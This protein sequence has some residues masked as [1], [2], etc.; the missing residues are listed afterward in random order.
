MGRGDSPPQ[1]RGQLPGALRPQRGSPGGEIAATEGLQRSGWRGCCRDLCLW[2]PVQ[3][4][5]ALRGRVK[6]LL[7]FLGSDSW[8]DAGRSTPQLLS[9]L[10]CHA[11]VCPCGCVHLCAPNA[12]LGRRPLGAQWFLQIPPLPCSCLLLDGALWLPAKRTRPRQGPSTPPASQGGPAAPQHGQGR[13][14]GPWLPAAPGGSPGRA[15]T[16]L[17]LVQ[18]TVLL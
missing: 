7:L 2:Q 11:Q 18:A 16:P 3:P 14:T 6:G 1:A 13:G 9:V 5:L 17:A 8:Q 12:R 4:L 10:S 15:W